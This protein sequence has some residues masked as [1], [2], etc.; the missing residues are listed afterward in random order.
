MGRRVQ[1]TVVWT[2]MDP[3]SLDVNLEAGL[4]LEDVD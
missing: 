4:N 3:M 1:S 2:C